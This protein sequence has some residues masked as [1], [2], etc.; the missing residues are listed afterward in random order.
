MVSP[1]FALSTAFWIVRKSHL[2]LRLHTVQVWCGPFGAFCA[3]P[4]LP[5]LGYVVW[6]VACAAPAP[7]TAAESAA[8]DAMR[9]V[10][11]MTLSSLGTHDVPP[12]HPRHHVREDV[13]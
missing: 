12:R 2:P 3:V 4:G 9:W 13:A 11:R 1:A 8:S 6:A 10:V 7:S 5:G